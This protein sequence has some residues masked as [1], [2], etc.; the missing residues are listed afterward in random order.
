M[1]KLKMHTPDTTADNIER[2]AELF[3]N[4]VVETTDEK[5]LGK[6]VIDFDQLRQELSDRVVEGPRERYHLDWPG[7]REAQ[8]TANAPIAKT[9]RPNRNESIRF[10]LTKN[11]FIEGD[12]LDALKLLQE[13]YLNKVK[14]IYIDP[15][16]NTGNDFVYDDDFSEDTQTFFRRSLQVDA[17]GNRLLLNTDSS[18]RYHSAWL[19]MLY[20][21]LKIARNLLRSDGVI[22]ISINDIEVPNVRKLCDELFGSENF[23]GQIIWHSKKGGGGGVQ[24]LVTEHEYIVAYAKSDPDDAVGKLQ[25]E[26]LPLDLADEQGPYRKSRELNKWGAGSAR[27]DR[28]TMYFPIPG[29]NGEDVYPIRN[30]GTEGR[31]RLGKRAMLKIVNEK[32]ALYEKRDDGSFIVYEKIRSADVR[33]KSYRTILSDAGSAAEG[34]ARLKELFD[35]KSPFDYPKPVQLL[36][37]LFDIGAVD[38]GDIVLDFYAGSG[39]TGDAVMDYATKSECS[40]S[41][42][43]VQLPQPIDGPYATISAV[44][45][46]RLRRAGNDIKEKAGLNDENLDIGFRVLRVDSSNMKDVYYQP[47]AVSQANLAGLVD[48]VK[49]DRADE[50]LLFQVLLDWGVDLTLPMRLE[51]VTGKKVY[52][53]DT[54]AVAACFEPGINEAFIKEL[55][56]RRDPWGSCVVC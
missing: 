46:E 41:F 30:D 39:T 4:C 2:I 55:S 53:V 5:G 1:T 24:T 22:F 28:P 6:R 29:P 38:D 56:K 15:P 27:E 40:L 13:T 17:D 8:L 23:L 34:T 18:G 43:L 21:R 35:G 45:K 32:N 47:D 20:P 48:N 26:A 54:N 37:K 33:F 44:A 49:D 19:T 51:T 36:H 9:L 10:D 31:W 52:F 42:I 3:P 12:N 50:D 16:Y 7:K 14:L 11:L 25:V